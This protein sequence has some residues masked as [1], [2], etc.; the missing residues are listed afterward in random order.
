MTQRAKVVET[1]DGYAVIEVSR[2]AMCDG[3]H[4]SCGSSCPMAGIFG[5]GKSARARAKNH[6]GAAVGDVVTVE[7]GASSVLLPAAMLFLLPLIIAA[8]FYAA[9]YHLSANQ[10]ASLISAI[11]GFVAAFGIS[12]I[13]EKR[14]RTREP[15]IRITAIVENANEHLK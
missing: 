12:A 7:A 10:N 8:A 1:A 13:A 3:C 9:A 11:A 4:N 5:K 15:E 2:A 6:V 14:K